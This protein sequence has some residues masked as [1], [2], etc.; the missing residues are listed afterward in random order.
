M[1]QPAPGD[2]QRVLAALGSPIRR[3]ILW[4]VW[5]EELPAGD[6]AR[7][8][9]VS[10]P[11]I[12]QHLAVLRD[13]GLVD[14][15]VDRTFRRYRA[16]QDVIGR[17]RTLIPDDTDKWA[18]GTST[19][20]LAAYRSAGLVVAEVEAP[21]SASDAYRAF[22]DAELYTRWSGVPVSIVDGQFSCTMEWGLRVRGTYDIAVAPSLIA[23]R[24]DVGTAEIPLPGAGT[25]AYLEFVP[26]ETGCRLV[27]RQ[28]VDTDE[29][30]RFMERAWGVMLGRFRDHV[31]TALDPAVPTTLRPTRSRDTE[32]AAPSDTGARRR[33]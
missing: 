21:C 14:M 9:E 18:P 2:T 17:L 15:R 24:W 8:F 12:S 27:L 3:E 11:T 30:G 5:D 7:S 16:R 26:T 29:Q 33:R 20:P 13:A 10:G 1:T 6:I 28:V 19:V 32:V 23:M 22:T 4:L 25:R 31:L